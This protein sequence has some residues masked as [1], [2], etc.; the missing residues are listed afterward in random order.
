MVGGNRQRSASG[1]MNAAWRRPRLSIVA[2]LMVPLLLMQAA[3]ST[4][5]QHNAAPPRSTASV[6]VDPHK[7][8]TL[9]LRNGFR[10]VVPAGAVTRAGRLAVTARPASMPAPPSMELAGPMYA[11]RLHGAGLRHAVRISIPV[12]VPHQRGIAAGPDA[13][14]LSY[15]DSVAGK[16]RSSP[17]TYDLAS[18]TLSADIPHL[19][20]C[21]A[22]KLNPQQTLDAIHSALVGFLGVASSSQ[23]NCPGSNSLPSSGVQV[24]AD[25]GDQVSWCPDVTSTG[26]VLRIVSKRTYAMEAS[27]PS[28]WSATL[29]G[30][31]DP[32]TSAIL[33]R[34]PVITPR[35]SGPGVHTSI[36]PGGGELDVQPQPGTSGRVII[37]VSGEGIFMQPLTYAAT[38]LAMVYGRLPGAAAGTAMRTSEVISEMFTDGGC[39]KELSAAYR[40]PDVSTSRAAGGLFRNL[41]DVAASCLATYWTED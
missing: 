34:I 27:Y 25:T 21:A 39:V 2:V 19:S 4:A 14:M 18:R 41:T 40:N 29:A 26:G 24:T 11:L 8:A 28:H 6:Q 5:A 7:T 15:Y 38:T 1:A 17:A 23:P 3:C 37:G 20:D 13:V 35:A 33:T 9:R 31:V 36:I 12:P 16:W 22:M 10:V 30:P 32:V